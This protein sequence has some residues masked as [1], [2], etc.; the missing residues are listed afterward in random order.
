MSLKHPYGYRAKEIVEIISKYAPEKN[1]FHCEQKTCFS[2]KS[3]CLAEYTLSDR[4]LATLTGTAFDYLARFQIA[5][6]AEKSRKSVC[7]HLIAKRLYEKHSW[8]WLDNQEARVEGVTAYNNLIS[9]IMRYVDGKD[10]ESDKVIDCCILLAKMEQ[11]YRGG[12]ADAP[13]IVINSTDYEIKEDLTRLLKVFNEAFL[14]LVKKTSTVVFNPT[15]GI[16]SLMVGGADADVFIDGTLYDFKVHKENGWRSADAKQLMGYYLL[17]AVAKAAKD[18]ENK[19]KGVNIHR[20]ALYSARYGEVAVMDTSLLEK[21]EL[22][23][24]VERICRAYLKCELSYIEE[25]IVKNIGIPISNEELWLC[26][27]ENR[28]Y[29]QILEEDVQSKRSLREAKKLRKAQQKLDKYLDEVD[30]IELISMIK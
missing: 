14:P 29:V 8:R 3:P 4:Y 26:N 6:K 24:A 2:K 10:D 12:H 11:E 15:F 18:K 9:F 17:D 13:K 21:A 19:L 27:E 5:R 7:E 25:E 20:I 16:A 22:R 30:C 1:Q 23:Q 28:M